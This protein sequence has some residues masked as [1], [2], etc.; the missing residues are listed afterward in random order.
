MSSSQDA[1]QRRIAPNYDKRK[2]AYDTDETSSS[3]DEEEPGW[4]HRPDE[5]YVLSTRHSAPR[6]I[7]TNS[8]V[9]WQDEDELRT[10]QRYLQT[11]L[12]RYS[13]P[14]A[15]ESIDFPLATSPPTQPVR[16]RLSV[17]D[18]SNLGSSQDRQRLRDYSTSPP[19]PYLPYLNKHLQSNDIGTYLPLHTS[20]G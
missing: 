8:R 15:I 4:R 3:D 16:R 18:N 12:S 13:N 9:K 14:F 20:S 17:P 11:Q 5:Q 2:D 7:K 1:P 10:S 6:R 19:P